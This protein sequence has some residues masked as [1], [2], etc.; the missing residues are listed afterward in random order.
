[1]L[2][3]TDG[4]PGFIEGKGRF[5]RRIEL[6]EASIRIYSVSLRNQWSGEFPHW[7]VL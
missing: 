3:T 4:K 5:L 6:N 1:M 2:F 7:I